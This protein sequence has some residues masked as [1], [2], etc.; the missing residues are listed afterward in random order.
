M[1]LR[2]L[3][4]GSLVGFVLL[5]AGIGT[6]VGAAG[7]GADVAT[8]GSVCALP[9]AP[10]PNCVSDCDAKLG[11]IAAEGYGGDFQAYLTCLSNAGDYAAGTGACE[12]QATTV[13]E[14][15][16][17]VASG[18]GDGPDSGVMTLPVPEEDAGRVASGPCVLGGNCGSV[19]STCTIAGAGPCGS[20]ERLAC[21]AAS[22]QY[23][24]DGFPCSTGLGVAC[25]FGTAGG[26][27][28]VGCNETCSCQDGLEVCT[29]DCPDGGP[30]SP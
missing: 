24:A 17:R 4:G 16:A 10:A 9:N 12:E 3:L 27:G 19:G 28:T 20:D 22:L 1:N 21:D 14:D 18:G 29:G 30:S 7:C 13:A 23:A 25:G 11:G 2:I 6:A 26:D 8:C 5:G 15:Y